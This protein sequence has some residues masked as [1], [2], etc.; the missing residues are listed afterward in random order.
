MAF[1]EG[2]VARVEMLLA[3]TDR[4]VLIGVAGAPGAGKTTLAELLV[5]RLGGFPRAAHVPMDGFHLAKVELERLGRADRMGAPDTFDVDGYAVLLHRIRRG[6]AVWAPSFERTLEQPL[7]QAIPVL[8]DTRV[9][10]SEGNYLL[11][12]EAEWR[13]VRAQFD[14][15]WFCH[16]NAAERLRRLIARHVAFGK[17]REE[18]REW[19]L[20]SDER[21]AELVAATADAADL[22]VDVDLLGLD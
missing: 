3:G 11:L 6:Q 18:A 1:A 8:A 9:V 19:V 5:A 4:R 7:A 22:I 20:R 14:E 10:V 12:P 17:S 15:V 16:V 2:L 21:N 13:V